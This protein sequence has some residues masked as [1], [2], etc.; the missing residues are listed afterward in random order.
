MVKVSL[1]VIALNEEDNIGLLL[2]SIAAQDYDHSLIEII[3]VDSGSVDSTKS[4]MSEFKERRKDFSVKVLDNP[5]KIQASGWNVAICA[6]SGDV[7][8]RAD[9]HS[10]LPNDFVRNNVECIESGE[11]VCGGQTVKIAK[12]DNFKQRLLLMAENSM[13]GSGAA[14]YRRGAEDRYVKT[15]A[16]GCYRMEVFE[17]VGLFNEKLRRSEDN[18]LHY[19]IRKAGYRIFMSSKIKSEYLSRSS[20]KGM[21]KQKYGNGKWVGITTKISPS[22]FSPYHYVPL[23]FAIA[24]FICF[25]MFIASL[26]P[27]VTDWLGL[28]FLIGCAAYLIVDILLT[29]ISCHKCGTAKAIF[30]LLIIFPLLHF[31]YGIGTIAGLLQAPFADLDFDACLRIR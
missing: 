10:V 24:A 15:I 13:F 6:A 26:F 12:E 1:G 23:A 4:K 18:E 22:I 29:L 27:A 9:A 20:L 7:F 2:N 14:K 17:K 19:R 21:L 3:L 5:R 30:L 31:A 8:I 28:P 11:Y 25:G 16:Q